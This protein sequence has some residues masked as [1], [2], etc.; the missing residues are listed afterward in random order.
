MEIL[1]ATVKAWTANDADA[2]A[3]LYAEDATVALSTGVFLQG[4]EEIRA[5]M[6]AGF[7]GMLKDSTGLDEP[8][9]VRMPGP[10]TAIVISRSGFTLPGQEPHVR[11]ATWVLSRHDGDW[12]VDAYANC[13]VLQES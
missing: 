8:Q 4:R 7:A 11:R 10:D 12:L 3:R 1:Q 9:S 13:P 2:Y 5:Y 6:T